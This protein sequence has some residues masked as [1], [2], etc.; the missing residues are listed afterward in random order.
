MNTNEQ[1]KFCWLASSTEHFFFF[2]FSLLD[3]FFIYISNVF[4]FPG[5]PFRNPLSDPPSSC[6]YEGASPTTHRL[7]LSHPGIPLH[8]G[9]KHPQAQGPLLQLISNKPIHCHIRGQSHGYLHVYSL[10]VGPVPSSSWGSGLLTRLLPAWGCKSPQLLQSLLILLYQNPHSVQRLASSINLC[11][12]KA[13]EEPLRR[14]PYQASISKHFSESTITSR[15]ASCIWH[16]SLSR[17]VFGW[18]FLQSLVHTLSL[19]FLL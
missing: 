1:G 5:V 11:I 9:I 17:A 8:W 16:G 13:L 15:F 2:F 7:L 3:I 18:P 6:L 19:Y 10:V 12:C 14:Q 4:P